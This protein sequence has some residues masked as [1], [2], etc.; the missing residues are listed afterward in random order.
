VPATSISISIPFPE[1]ANLVGYSANGF[2]GNYIDAQMTDDAIM[3]THR[4]EHPDPAGI[5]KDFDG[6]LA[7]V[8][9]ALRFVR[10]QA[11]QFK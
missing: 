7:Q 9:N 8:E 5:K 2:G 4:S 10:E 11:K 1:D 3:M 6:R